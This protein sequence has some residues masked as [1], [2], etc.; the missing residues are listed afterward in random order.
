MTSPVEEASDRRQRVCF[1]S[2]AT[3]GGL[4]FSALQEACYRNLSAESIDAL[5]FN[6]TIDGV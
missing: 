4:V 3:S 5:A 2:M 6:V 1:V